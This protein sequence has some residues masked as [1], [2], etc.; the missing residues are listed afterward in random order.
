MDEIVEELLKGI[1]I[2]TSTAIFG[3]IFAAITEGNKTKTS[4]GI[5]AGFS[6]WIPENSWRYFIIFPQESLEK[7]RNT[8]LNGFERNI[9][10][11]IF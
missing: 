2:W 3:E 9:L 7:F 10:T 5:P 1:F 11:R 4:G 6:G 8:S